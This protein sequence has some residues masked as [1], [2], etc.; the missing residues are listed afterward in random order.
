MSDNSGQLVLNFIEVD[1]WLGSYDLT[2]EG[3]VAVVE[4]TASSIGPWSRIV[5][6]A[7]LLVARNYIVYE[8]KRYTEKFCNLSHG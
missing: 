6:L 7:E 5:D 3:Q 1:G 2:N 4:R 8:S